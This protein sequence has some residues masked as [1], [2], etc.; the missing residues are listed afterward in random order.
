MSVQRTKK[1]AKQYLRKELKREKWV[2]EEVWKHPSMKAAVREFLD[3][4]TEESDLVDEAKSLLAIRDARPPSPDPATKHSVVGKPDKAEWSRT[5]AYSNQIA[6][7]ASRHV[8]EFRTRVLDGQ[9][10]THEE[11]TP[12]L[13]SMALASVGL[14]T[15]RKKGIPLRHHSAVASAIDVMENTPGHRLYEMDLDVSWKGGSTSLRPWV[16]T[17][18]FGGNPFGELSYKATDGMLSKPYMALTWPD[19][20]LDDLRQVS[21]FLSKEFPWSP[22]R[23]TWFVLTGETPLMTSS[24]MTWSQKSYAIDQERGFSFSPI[25]IHAQPWVNEKAVAKLFGKA[26]RKILQTAKCRISQRVLDVFAFVMDRR[27]EDPDLTLAQLGREWNREN[28]NRQYTSD[29][30]FRSAFE[31]CEK[32]LMHFNPTER[33]EETGEELGIKN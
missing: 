17:P 19:S 8:G 21:R 32:K 16:V 11:A 12:F 24:R 4:A 29:R 5:V 20:V 31:N 3:E 1:S 33:Q 25:T 30:G 10:L 18:E 27:L 7:L 23:A 28:K 6:R 14:D 13:R 9:L 22:G 2:F 15:C 26:Q